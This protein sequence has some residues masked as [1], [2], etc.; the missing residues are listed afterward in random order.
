MRNSIIR[1]EQ[2]PE[3]EE[4][5]RQLQHRLLDLKQLTNE[6]EEDIKIQ[7][8]AKDE[9]HNRELEQL[10]RERD[11]VRLEQLPEL[12]GKMQRIEF[13]L[14]HL[15]KEIK[16][17]ARTAAEEHGR[18]VE[19]LRKEKD[20]AKAEK[21]DSYAAQEAEIELLQEISEQRQVEGMYEAVG[22]TTSSIK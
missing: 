19:Q 5:I 14:V 16:D 4:K 22:N 11:V 20:S 13:Q 10:R 1:L 6:R 15:R 21:V 9:E 2:L 12:K 18:E 17:Q 8:R 7:S 3:L